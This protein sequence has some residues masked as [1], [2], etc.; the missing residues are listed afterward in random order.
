MNKMQYR[1]Y[2][3]SAHWQNVKNRYYKTH[4]YICVRCGWRKGLQ[5]HHL[6]Y[7]RVGREKM[8]DLIYLCRRCHMAE[9]GLLRVER[10]KWSWKVK[11]CIFVALVWFVVACWNYQGK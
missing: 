6:T 2:L 11:V 10:K 1:A 7:K 5:L 8:D 3:K 4:E 9:H